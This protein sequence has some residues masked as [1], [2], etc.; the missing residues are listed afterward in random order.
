M[1]QN[2]KPKTIAIA[3]GD[4]EF[5]RTVSD[6]ARD[7]AKA[8]GLTIVYDKSYPPTT[9]DYTPIVRAVQAADPDIFYI[10]AY[11][12][13]S[14]GLVR[15][16]NE[17]GYR[18][19]MFGGA[20]VGL[21]NVSIKMQLGPLLNG[22][23]GY[24]NWIPSPQM[25]FPGVEAL[26]KT[27]QAEAKGEGL[28]LLGYGAVPS[29]YSYV[30]VLGE[31]VAGAGSLDQDK[32]AAYMHSHSFSTVWGEV[33]FADSGEWVDPRML[34]VQYRGI[35]GKTID[36]FTDPAKMPVVDPPQFKSGDLIYPYAD[37]VK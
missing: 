28:D 8:A 9:T 36:Q 23:V 37:A 26:L 20:T 32:I 14:V 31:G 11:P 29:A 3:A 2:P 4:I 22:V 25:M 6:A 15:A 30:Q 1:Q 27:Y 10:A 19:K 34:V 21:N 5:S 13:D 12:Q 16:V 35:T 7:N 33:R 18:P 24:E 17:I